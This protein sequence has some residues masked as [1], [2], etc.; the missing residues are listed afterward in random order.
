MLKDGFYLSTYISISDINNV[1]STCVRHD[2]NMAL[3]RK[4]GSKI[5][6]VHYWEFE[7]YTGEKHQYRSFYS[8]EQAKEVINH[9]LKE[10]DITL[11]DIVEIWG[12]PAL[13]KGK[14]AVPI[15]KKDERFTHHSYAHLFSCLFSEKKIFDENT[16]IALEVDGGPDGECDKGMYNKYLYMGSVSNKGEILG[17]EPIASPA[18]L[19]LRAKN[20]LGLEEG[21]LMALGSACTAVYNKADDIFDEIF[22]Y[23][24][25]ERERKK[26]DELIETVMRVDLKD[27]NSVTAFDCRFSDLENR[28]SMIVKIITEYSFGVLEKNIDRIASKYSINKEE[29]FLALSGGFALN[30][31]INTRLIVQFKKK[32]LAPPCVNDTGISLGVGLWKFYTD[33]ASFSFSLKNAYWGNGCSDDEVYESINSIKFKPYIAKATGYIADDVVEDVIN[34]PIVWVSGR[35][36]IGPRALGA[37]SL[38]GDPRNNRT[39]DI[40]NEIKQRQWWRPVAPIVMEETVCEWFENAYETKY[41]LNTFILRQEKVELVPAIRHLDGSAR[42]QTLNRDDNTMLYDVLERFYMKT[43]V[44]MLCNT[45]LNDKGEPIINTVDEALHFAL[46]KGIK[47]VY[48]NRWRIELVNHNGYAERGHYKRLYDL[49]AYGEMKKQIDDKIRFLLEILSDREIHHY[50]CNH[51]LYKKY[52]LSDCG[53]VKKLKKILSKMAKNDELSGDVMLRD[54]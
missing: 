20:V 37:R 27:K 11:T 48:V 28:I 34:E 14:D 17:F 5:S 10:Y 26:L 19:W 41:M 13:E 39:K 8:I 18:L 46:K 47:V 40:L 22:S 2:Q 21:T 43:N 50:L 1:L 16:I 12:T 31:P 52:D 44:P 7:R 32:L 36:E 23:L 29:T 15:E 45:S 3:W 49:K 53:Q 33:N 9:M 35:A 4:E 25:Y 54:L 30:C 6:L 42:V 38:L 51:F 24:D